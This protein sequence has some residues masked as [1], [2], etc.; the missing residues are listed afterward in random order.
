[1]L[2]WLENT[3]FM[4]W[5]KTI[6]KKILENS[7]KIIF[8][9]LP[10]Y[11]KWRWFLWLSFTNL[12]LAFLYLLLAFPPSLHNTISDYLGWQVTASKSILSG[13]FSIQYS[14]IHRWTLSGSLSQIKR[15][16]FVY[17]LTVF[18]IRIDLIRIP[19]RIWVQLL[20]EC[21]SGSSNEN[22]WR[23]IRIRIQGAR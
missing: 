13:T 3:R 1:M 6:V 20:S 23:S 15:Q 8:S 7:F 16:L 19:T 10:R 14:L 2:I 12:T 4:A 5:K 11:I 21:G 22:E 9:V 17:F 18:R